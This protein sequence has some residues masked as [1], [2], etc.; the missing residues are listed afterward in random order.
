VKGL[1]TAII[2]IVV[3]VAPGTAAAKVLGDWRL[4]EGAGQVARDSS[5]GG[6]HGQLGEQPQ[7]DWHDPLWVPGRFGRGLRFEG[8]RNQYVVVPPLGTPPERLTVGAWIR[9]LGTPGRW[10]YLVSSGGTGC[11]FASFGLYSSFNGGLAFYVGDENGYAA[12]PL[13]A[14]QA[15]WDGNWHF[16]AGTYDG[17]QV[18]LYLDGLEV[19]AGTP[20]VLGIHYGTDRTL[21]IGTYKG[22]C[23]LPFTGDIDEVTIHDRALAAAEIRAAALA[24]RGR[25]APPQLPPVGGPPS[26]RRPA[27]CLRVR[28]TPRRLRSR[29]LTRL[30]VSVRLAGRGVARRR[31][32]VR[33]PGLRRTLRTGPRGRAQL[34]VRPRRRGALRVTVPGQPRRCGVRRVRIA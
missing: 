18:R 21:R 34:L 9:R 27:P 22:T 33:G 6:H 10:R 1:T 8:L 5:G 32:V 20:A 24:S 12:S 15:A 17:R 11:D 26:V 4:D 29:R 28:V 3:L 23:D 14:P 25:E 2:A 31:V 13:A 19:G 30:R 7:V 16:A